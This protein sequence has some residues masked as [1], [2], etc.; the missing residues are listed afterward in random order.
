MQDVIGEVK[1]DNGLGEGTALRSWSDRTIAL[2]ES[3]GR[4]TKEPINYKRY[5]E[6]VGFVDVNVEVFKWAYGDWM[7]EPKFKEMG[8]W[9]RVNQIGL[10]QSFSRRAR[11]PGG[12]TEEEDDAEIEA[13][14]KEMLN[15]EIRSYLDL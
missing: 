2:V 4:P 12:R 14:G 8:K 5:M 9:M 7:D 1:F 10:M 13:V 11:V 3:R 15:P 6:E